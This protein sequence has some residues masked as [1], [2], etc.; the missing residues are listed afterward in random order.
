MRSF[1]GDVTILPPNGDL[2]RELVRRASSGRPQIIRDDE[3]REAVLVSKEQWQADRES[4]RVFLTKGGNG[5]DE[6]STDDMVD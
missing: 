5:P 3:G 1:A 6:D 4:L 2:L